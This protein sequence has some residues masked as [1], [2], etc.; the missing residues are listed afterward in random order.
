MQ[1]D[2]LP[3]FSTLKDLRIPLL[4]GGRFSYESCLVLAMLTVKRV[5]H[6]QHGVWQGKREGGL[7]SNT[8]LLVAI[9][10]RVSEYMSGGYGWVGGVILAL[11]SLH[12]LA[13]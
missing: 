10:P 5:C 13:V 6:T 2:V 4:V 9:L 11:V 8:T 1:T 3:F 7:F 12:M